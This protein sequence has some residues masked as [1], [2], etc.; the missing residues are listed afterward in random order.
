LEL[1]TAPVVLVFSIGWGEWSALLAG[2]FTPAE[3]SPH[4]LLGSRLYA[5]WFIIIKN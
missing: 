3:R 1:G 5:K 2:Q 4:A